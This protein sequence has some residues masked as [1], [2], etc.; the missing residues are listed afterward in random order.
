MRKLFLC[1]LAGLTLLC[2]CSKTD[3]NQ[4]S[5][6]KMQ[7]YLTY[8]KSMTEM[9]RFLPSSSFY[10][11]E[12]VMNQLPDGTY[13]Y[14]VILDNPQVA[15]YDVQLLAADTRVDYNLQ[16]TLAP[17][18]GLFED[19]EYSLIPYQSYPE[20][21]YVKGLVASGE[22]SEVTVELLVMVSW[23]DYAKLNETREYLRIT[24]DF[25]A[26]T[27]AEDAAQT[28]TAQP[29]PQP[30]ETATPESSPADEGAE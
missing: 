28:E 12:V 8:Y 27:S 11:L 4:I 17:S 23:Y 24:G 26:Q 15:M 19:Q 5:E 13:R 14:Y 1:F 29:T 18:V 20:L 16:Q 2:G 9:D 3:S 7:L 10:D 25:N 30:E 21:G 22:S 6:E